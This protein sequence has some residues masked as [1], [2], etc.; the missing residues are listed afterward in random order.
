M[1][2]ITAAKSY[3]DVGLS[4]VVS[5]EGKEGWVDIHS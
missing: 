5:E 4:L 1:Y 3:K 2:K